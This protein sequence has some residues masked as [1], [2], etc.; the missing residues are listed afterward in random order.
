MLPALEMWILGESA[1]SAAHPTT[2]IT[3][4]QLPTAKAQVTA[5]GC[6]IGAGHGDA[7]YMACVLV[8]TLRCYCNNLDMAPPNPNPR[9]R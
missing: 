5:A 1:K 8:W 7:R 2:S 9:V 6:R 4:Q 3:C